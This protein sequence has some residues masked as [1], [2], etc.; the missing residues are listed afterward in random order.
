MGFSFTTIDEINELEQMKTVDTIG[1]VTEVTPISKVNIKSTGVE[2]DRRNV[3]IVDESGLKIQ[4][5]LWGGLARRS[6]YSE[7]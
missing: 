6:D 2:K 1:V 5:S 3:S 4:I 7:G